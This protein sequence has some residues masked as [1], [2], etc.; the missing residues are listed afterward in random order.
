MDI[1]TI[2]SLNTNQVNDAPISATEKNQKSLE[3]V[4]GAFEKMVFEQVFSFTPIA[5]GNMSNLGYAQQN[6]IVND[7]YTEELHTQ[8]KGMLMD[9]FIKQ[10]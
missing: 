9:M 5:K 3:V 2:N 6:S 1:P 4:A 7:L 8:S 10:M